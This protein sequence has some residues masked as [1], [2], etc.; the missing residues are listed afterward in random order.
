[1][2][3]FELKHFFSKAIASEQGDDICATAVQAIIKRIVAQELPG[4]PISDNSI[5]NIL[6]NQGYVIAR[7]TVAKYRE[8]LRIPAMHLRRH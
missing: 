3:L 2:G 7:R 4:K 6:E 1:L 5:A 8:S